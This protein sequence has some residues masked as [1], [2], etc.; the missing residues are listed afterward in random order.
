VAS[1]SHIDQDALRP[2]GEQVEDSEDCENF[3][4]SG[5][6]ALQQLFKQLPFEPQIDVDLRPVRTQRRIDQIF[7]SRRPI[8]K[9]RYR[10]HLRCAKFRIAQD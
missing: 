3:V 4:H 7:N 1:R 8:L 6:N 2:F 5:R 10:I 9:R